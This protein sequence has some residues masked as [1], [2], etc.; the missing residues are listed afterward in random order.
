M[1]SLMISIDDMWMREANASLIEINNKASRHINMY[2]F[3]GRKPPDLEAQI[4]ARQFKN[5][6]LICIFWSQA[7]RACIMLRRSACM[8]EHRRFNRPNLN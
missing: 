8:H 4:I 1:F 6:E 2:L 5:S 3:Y 7:A